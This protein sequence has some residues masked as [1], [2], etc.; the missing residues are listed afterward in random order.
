MFRATSYLH[1]AFCLLHYEVLPPEPN[2]HRDVVGPAA[3]IDLG[4]FESVVEVA[5]GAVIADLPA[6]ADRL[7]AEAEAGDDDRTGLGAL[8]DIGV[9]E[10]LAAPGEVDEIARLA[11]APRDD[12]QPGAEVPR[13]RARLP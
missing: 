4:S 9:A 5:F 11:V 12:A 1:F 13:Q 2:P 10:D 3:Q 8:G 7:A 6:G